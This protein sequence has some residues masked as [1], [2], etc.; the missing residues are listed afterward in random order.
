[1]KLHHF[2]EMQQ[3]KEPI[4]EIDDTDVDTNSWNHCLIGYFLDEKMPYNLLCAT[5]RA[6]WKDNAPTSIKQLGAC[7]F[8]KFRDE[9]AKL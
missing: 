4:I 5:A 9:A 1:M 8:F 7:F 2:P 3:G 6:I